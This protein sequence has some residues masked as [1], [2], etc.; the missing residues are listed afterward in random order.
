[1]QMATLHHTQERAVG[2]LQAGQQEMNCSREHEKFEML[3]GGPLHVQLDWPP[4]KDPYK[5]QAASNLTFKEA[6]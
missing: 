3:Q 1:M 2:H 4:V 5:L 6:A